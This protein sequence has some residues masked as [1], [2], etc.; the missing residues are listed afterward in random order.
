VVHV[1]LSE[2]LTQVLFLRLDDPTVNNEE[3][4]RQ[5]EKW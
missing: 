1:F 4:A 3:D 2:A 5:G